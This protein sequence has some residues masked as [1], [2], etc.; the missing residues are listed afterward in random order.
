MRWDEKYL[1]IGGYSQEINVWANQTKHDSVGKMESMKI[2]V[3]LLEIICF[4]K[5]EM[6]SHK[7]F[8]FSVFK[9]NDFEVMY[10]PHIY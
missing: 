6:Y 5:V 1:Y 10:K 2:V 4:S 9:D 8:F 3:W 7:C